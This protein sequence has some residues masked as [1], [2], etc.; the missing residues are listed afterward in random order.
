[1]AFK[2][3][4]ATC[5]GTAYPQC[6]GRGYFRINIIIDRFHISNS[7]ILRSRADSAFMSHVILN[8][9]TVAII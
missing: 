9:W 4:E 3:T 2:S 7:V 6:I 5:A 8:E 1:M